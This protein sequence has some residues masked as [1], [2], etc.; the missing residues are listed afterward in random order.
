MRML[1]RPS[2]AAA[3][4]IGASRAGTAIRITS[5]LIADD[6]ASSHTTT[7]SAV[8]LDRRTDRRRCGPAGR[9]SPTMTVPGSARPAGPAPRPRSASTTISPGGDDVAR[10]TDVAGRF[11]H[12]RPVGRARRAPPRR[13]PAPVDRPRRR[14]PSPTPRGSCPRRAVRRRDGRCSRG[15]RR[16]PRRP[17]RRT[18]P[19]GSTDGRRA[20]AAFSRRCAWWSP[21][22]MR[23]RCVAGSWGD[24]VRDGCRSGDRPAAVPA[25]RGAMNA[26]GCAPVGRRESAVRSA[27]GYGSAGSAVV[28]SSR[29]LATLCRIVANTASIVTGSWPS[30]PAS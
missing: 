22:L 30:T 13:S 21:R 3:A 18:R 20:L 16:R 4:T 28:I 17:A 7:P 12:A 10:A 8:D 26:I 11:G 19:S 6:L 9:S 15:S 1:A 25:G 5:S 24:A 23:E 2:W 27:S 29:T 14:L